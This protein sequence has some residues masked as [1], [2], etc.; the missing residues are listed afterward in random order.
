MK[1]S[2]ACLLICRTIREADFL[3]FQETGEASGFFKK[4]SEFIEC[5]GH[6]SDNGNDFSAIPWREKPEMVLHMVINFE[7]SQVDRKKVTLADL[8]SGG[9]LNYPIRLFYKRAREFRL[10][11]EQVSGIYTYG[12]GLFR[13][14]F[15]ALGSHFVQR[16]LIT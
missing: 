9:K 7:P 8:R 16:D 15:L 11:R 2:F 13:Y 5:F 14:F 4:I 10:L 12:Y 3:Q 1:N 6:L